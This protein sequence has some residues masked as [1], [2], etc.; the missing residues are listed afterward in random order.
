VLPRS[1]PGPHSFSLEREISSVPW[2]VGSA[3]HCVVP[4]QDLQLEERQ[5]HLGGPVLPLATRQARASARSLPGTPACSFA[6]W[7]DAS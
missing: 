4:V 5:G 3:I 2:L 7:R 6:Q 1:E